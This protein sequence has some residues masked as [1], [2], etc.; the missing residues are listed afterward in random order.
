[1]Y[2]YNNEVVSISKNLKPSERGELEIT[3][4]NKEYLN[5]GKLQVVKIGR[6]VAWLDTGNPQ[7]L[8]QAS[9]F[10][11][12]I[13]D[14]QGLKVACPEEIA[15]HNK[16]IDRADFERVIKNMPDSLYRN[17]LERVLNDEF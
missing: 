2:V 10:F 4:V 5:K 17:Y 15:Y 13:E 3:D 11:G 16:F 7:S 8:L 9:N 6:G 1:L 12:V 14:R